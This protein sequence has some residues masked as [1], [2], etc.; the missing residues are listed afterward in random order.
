MEPLTAI[1]LCNDSIAIHAVQTLAFHQQLMAVAIPASNK[2]VIR[3]VREI[4]PTNI[5]VI[6]LNKKEWKQQV[7]AL[8]SSP[9]SNLGL[10]MTFPWKLDRD[11][12]CLPARGFY[13]FHYGL[14]PQY[15]GADPLFYQVKNREPFAGLTIHLVEEAMDEGNIVMQEKMQLKKNYT[16]GWL[17][18]SMSFLGGQMAGKLMEILSYS[19]KLI[20]RPQDKEKAVWFNRPGPEQVMINWEEMDSDDTIAL[21]NACNPWNKGAGAFINGMVIKILEVE[22]VSDSKS[23]NFLPG[24]IIILNSGDV[25]VVTA[26]HSMIKLKIIY[27]PE[28]FMSAGRL[29]E[30]GIKE[31]DMFSRPIK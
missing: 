28:G 20:T 13:N 12:I 25:L 27:T 30:Y 15:R 10:L 22:K 7:K 23:E 11:T 16:Y 17:K 4:L 29:I 3:E 21:I 8:F 5:P 14:L 2:E 1:V 31:G 9:G 6:E 24:R 19:E 26:D 18:N